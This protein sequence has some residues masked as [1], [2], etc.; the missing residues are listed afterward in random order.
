MLIPK[1]ERSESTYDPEVVKGTND[2]KVT[3]DTTDPKESKDVNDN[4]PKQLT[5]KQLKEYPESVRNLSLPEST[6]EGQIQVG[7]GRGKPFWLN[8]KL[9]GEGP[10]RIVWLCG[11]GDTIKAWRRHVL[12]FG[13]SNSDG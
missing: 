6:K 1:I 2:R 4:K 11:H 7:A 9:Y 10:T 5:V 13:H 8:Y 3:E 12:Y